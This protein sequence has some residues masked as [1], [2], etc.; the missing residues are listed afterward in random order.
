[1]RGGAQL[2][3]TDLRRST[4]HPV[5]LPVIG[6]HRTRGDIMLHLA[7]ISTTGFL[8]TEVED[9]GRGE[10][11]TVR[12][13]VIGRIEAFVVWVDGGRAGFQFERIVRVDEFA[14]MIRALQV[15]PKAR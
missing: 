13:P 8:A 4:R 11:L 7:N 5:N 1:M 14:K 3:V 10:R 6:E 9:L 15:N 2:S 12:L